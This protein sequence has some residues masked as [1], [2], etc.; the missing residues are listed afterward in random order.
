MTV[1]FTHFQ[2]SRLSI[3]SKGIQ[4]QQKGQNTPFEPFIGSGR[5]GNLSSV[6]DLIEGAFTFEIL[7]RA[8]ALQNFSRWCV[9][10]LV[11]TV[12]SVGATVGLVGSFEL[13][14]GVWF[15]VR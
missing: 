10:G 14:S 4:R 11:F 13:S 8:K 3:S 15:W 12:S 5:G 1:I 6:W 2:F 9:V 7:E